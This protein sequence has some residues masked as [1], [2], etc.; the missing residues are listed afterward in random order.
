MSLKYKTR[1]DLYAQYTDWQTQDDFFP[2]R[3]AKYNGCAPNKM[4]KL[5]PSVKIVFNKPMLQADKI[6]IDVKI[7]S[8]EPDLNPKW[9]TSG[10]RVDIILKSVYTV[11]Q[12]KALAKKLK[13]CIADNFK[14]VVV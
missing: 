9:T 8:C 3:P 13:Q 10:W 12:A 6:I 2:E 5:K 1:P 4:V 11:S 7:N 14:I